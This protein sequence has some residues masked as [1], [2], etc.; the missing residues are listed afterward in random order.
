MKLKFLLLSFVFVLGFLVVSPE[1]DVY[2]EEASVDLPSITFYEDGEEIFP[3]TEE[4]LIAM[5]N[6]ELSI[7]PQNRIYN[8]GSFSVTNF[9]YVGGSPTSFWRNPVY[10]ASEK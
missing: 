4:E 9:V 7:T 2:A 1:K 3:Y 5:Q 8:L 10:F 6:Q